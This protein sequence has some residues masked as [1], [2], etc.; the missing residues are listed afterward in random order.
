MTRRTVLLLVLFV[1]LIFFG[2]SNFKLS[3]GRQYAA[4]QPTANFVNRFV[5]PQLNN[6]PVVSTGVNIQKILEMMKQGYYSDVEAASL[7]AVVVGEDFDAYVQYRHA[8]KVYWTKS[9]HTIRKGTLLFCDRLG[10][11]VKADCGNEISLTPQSP[12]QPDEPFDTVLVEGPPED[13]P[14]PTL[15]G[16]VPPTTTTPEPPGVGPEPPPS[17]FCCLTGSPVPPSTPV[18]VQTPEP[19][20]F[21]LVFA[22]VVALFVF[23]KRHERKF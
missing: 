4:A 5:K 17:T 12:D 16:V 18:P 8:G 23:G 7:H 22:G 3:S 15:E 14:A 2:L 1:L 13:V 10:R 6:F 19:S 9:K 21:Y 11:C 20:V